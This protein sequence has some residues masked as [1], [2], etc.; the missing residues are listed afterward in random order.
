MES[1]KTKG[2]A[3]PAWAATS[4]GLKYTE[5]AGPMSAADMTTAPPRPMAPRFRPVGA[6][7]GA[8]DEAE[9]AGAAALSVIGKTAFWVVTR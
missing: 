7:G 1:A 9:A 3:A 4:W 5:T 8:G 6:S 2:V